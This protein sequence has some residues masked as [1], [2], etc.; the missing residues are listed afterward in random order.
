MRDEAVVDA[1]KGYRHWSARRQ[2]YFHKNDM[3]YRF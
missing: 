1:S 2:H 3:R